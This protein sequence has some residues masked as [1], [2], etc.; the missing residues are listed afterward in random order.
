[1]AYNPIIS[2]MPVGI[3][4][5]TT[6]GASVINYVSGSISGDEVPVSLSPGK[7]TGWYIYNGDSTVARIAFYDATSAPAIGDIGA[8]FKFAIVI[9]SGA[10]ANVSIPAGIQFSTGISFNIGNAVDNSDS[11]P[12]GAGTVSVN[13]IYKG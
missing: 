11:N 5:I 6:G 9:P 1:M 8:S 12:I 10:A 13:V 3:Q 2:P 4:E 7:L